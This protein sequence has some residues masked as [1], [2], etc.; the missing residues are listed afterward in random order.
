MGL[1][2]PLCGKRGC[3]CE[4]G[5]EHEDRVVGVYVETEKV[6]TRGKGEKDE[7]KDGPV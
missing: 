4:V 7:L 5:G 6:E 1:P 3:G 2:G